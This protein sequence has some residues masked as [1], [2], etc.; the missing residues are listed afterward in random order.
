[1]RLAGIDIGSR[2]IKYAILEQG[3][4]VALTT[5]ETGHDP[6]SVCRALLDE[7]PADRVLATGYGRHL[8]EEDRK[9]RTITEIRAVARG[10]RHFFPSCATII[11]IGGQDTK[12]VGLAEKG[13]VANF[14]MNDRCAAGTGRFLEMMAHALGYSVDDFGRHCEEGHQVTVNSLCA[15]FAESEV[16]SLITKGVR[17]EAIATALHNS[18]VTRV[19]SLVNRVGVRDD[20][21]FAGGCARNSCLTTLLAQRLNKFLLIHPMPEMLSAVGAALC[22]GDLYAGNR[23]RPVA[24]QPH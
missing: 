10:A 15:V 13:T 7:M 16:I 11:D 21:V 18:I 6:L 22:A 23:T 1:V 12:V 17:R 2:Y 9:I 5:R 14:E 24:E 20:V 3:E 19:V 4:P 8:M